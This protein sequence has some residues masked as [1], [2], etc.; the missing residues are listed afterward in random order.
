MKIGI[1]AGNNLFPLL[2]CQSA[3]KKDSSL[4]IIAICFYGETNSL[5]S[6][7]VRKTFWLHVGEIECLL[8]ILQKEHIAKLVMA[9]QIS[10]RRIFYRKRWDATMLR[11]AETVKDFRPHTLFSHMICFLEQKGIEFLDSTMYIK[12]Y[13]A[14]DGV[15]NNV[16]VPCEVTGDVEFG[17]RLLSRFS[18]LDVGQTIVVKRRT[19]IALEG[20]DGT[21]RTIS[22]GCRLAGKGCTV[23]KF[24]KKDQDLRF[25]VPVVGRTTLNLLKRM[26]A[27]A[28]VLEQGRVIILEKERFLAE[29]NRWR[30][31][32]IGRRRSAQ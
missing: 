26:K 27:A 3:K 28:L 15:M 2:F 9:G 30:I 20:F 24:S 7:F 29:S 13:L 18:E 21:D 4:E 5:I 14:T 1:I 25:D 16:G 8:A 32:I 10:P 11:L 19:A 31:P 12:E 6:R 17:A 22:R 23:L